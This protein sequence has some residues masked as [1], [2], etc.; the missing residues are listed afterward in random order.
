MPPGS[1]PSTRC[2]RVRRVRSRRRSRCRC[3][4]GP[5][6]RDDGCGEKLRAAG[7]HAHAPAHDREAGVIGSADSLVADR[8]AHER[9]PVERNPAKLR[10]PRPVRLEAIARAAA[11]AALRIDRSDRRIGS[12]GSS[13]SSS[14]TVSLSQTSRKSASEWRS[15]CA[16]AN[17]RFAGGYSRQRRVEG[18]VDVFDIERFQCPARGRV[19]AKARA[20]RISE[21]RCI[22]VPARE[23]PDAPA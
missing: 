4:I 20:R 6:L 18:R 19:D 8:R 22:V 12:S 5:H 21:D 14:H 17:T 2:L 9:Q 15:A 7:Q 16:P 10:E 13:G 1:I 23:L 11:G 3:R